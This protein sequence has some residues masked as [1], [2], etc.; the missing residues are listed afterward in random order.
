MNG[1]ATRA[2]RVLPRF[3]MR[4]AVGLSLVLSAT[5]SGW[6]PVSATGDDDL[7]Q[8]PPQ[9]QRSARHF[10]LPFAV[11]PSES[12]FGKSEAGRKVKKLKRLEVQATDIAYSASTDELFL[13]I[14]SNSNLHPNSLIAVRPKSRKVLRVIPVGTNPRYMALSEA[15]RTAHVLVDG[16]RVQRVDLTQ[17]TVVSEFTP[18]IPGFNNP[19]LVA[20]IAVRPGSPGTVAVSFGFQGITGNAGTAIY[21]DGVMRPEYVPHFTVRQLIFDEDE[22]W[23]N[24]ADWAGASAAIFK[25]SVLPGGLRL[26][27]GG[28]AVS[29]GAHRVNYHGGRFYSDTGQIVDA[30]NFKQVGWIPGRDWRFAL[31]SAI[32]PAANR[33]YFANAR[34]FYQVIFAYDIAT[35]RVVSYFDG[36]PYRQRGEVTRLVACGPAGFAALTG[37]F[38]VS[39]PVVFYSPKVFKA[40]SPFTRPAPVPENGT[41]RVIALSHNALIYDD[42]ARKFY[43]TLGGNVPGAGSSVVEVDPYS[44]SVGR[45]VWIGSVPGITAISDDRQYLYVAMWGSYQIKRLRLPSLSEDVTFDLL[46]GSADTYGPYQTNAEEIMPLPGKSRSIAVLF[47][48]YPWVREQLSAE[49]AVYDDDVRRPTTTDYYQPL[50]GSVELSAD[51]MTIYGLNNQDTGSHFLTYTIGPAGVYRNQSYYGVGAAFFDDL[52]CVDGKCFTDVGVIIDALTG[53]RLGVLPYEAE[54]GASFAVVLDPERRLVYQAVSGR[55]L[56][57][58][59]YDMQTHQRVAALSLPGIS[60]NA[61]GLYL[62]DDGRQLAFSTGDE[63]YLIPTA[64]LRP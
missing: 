25:V 16:E 53:T 2:S 27:N 9:I 18:T 47:N 4:I 44:G 56:D 15:D 63:I 26:E 31:G 14:A 3:L 60:V 52:H 22:L 7:G 33:I 6:M 24:S 51:G 59:A 38:E 36:T 23:A 20:A 57:V 49:I 58:Y 12:S 8:L 30:S 40:Y 11:P 32:D 21:D 17:G 39:G 43:A 64:L 34:E 28:R 62:W 61:A 35:E 13:T 37:L 55:N 45:D 41:V 1:T 29:A 19:L 54:Y 46:R 42:A 5:L 48:G 10:E 50:A